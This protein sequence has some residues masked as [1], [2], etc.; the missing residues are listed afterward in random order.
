MI[1]LDLE[2]K[3]FLSIK[4]LKLDFPQGLILIDGFDEDRKRYC[5]TGKSAFLNTICYLYYGKFP[6]GGDYTLDEIVNDESDGRMSVSGTLEGRDHK[7]KIVRT[8]DANE[9]KSTFDIWI[10]GKKDAGA[11]DQRQSKITNTIGLTY[12]QFLLL[13]YISQKGEDRF[14]TM[15]SSDKKRFLSTILDLDRFDSAY[16]LAKRSADEKEATIASLTGSLEATRQMVSDCCGKVDVTAAEEAAANRAMENVDAEISSVTTKMA[17]DLAE[18]SVYEAG[19]SEGHALKVGVVTERIHG[20]RLS[21]AAKKKEVDEAANIVELQRNRLKDERGFVQNEIVRVRGTDGTDPVK[22]AA[23]SDEL[24]RLRPVI[25]AVGQARRD[26]TGKEHLFSYANKEI[27]R[28]RS[29][30]SIPAT[31]VCS[32]CG[33]KLP[34]PDIQKHLQSINIKIRAREEEAARLQE[35][36]VRYTEIVTRGAEIE[37]KERAILGQIEAERASWR[38][39]R[40]AA[41]GTLAAK[42]TELDLRI[43]SPDGLPALHKL[44]SEAGAIERDILSAQN[45]LREPQ[46]LAGVR[47]KTADLKRKIDLTTSEI[48]QRRTAA[49][50]AAKKAHHEATLNRDRWGNKLAESEASLVSVQSEQKYLLEAKKVF[51]PSGVRAFVFSDMLAH[52]NSRINHYLDIFWGGSIRFEY[53]VNEKGDFCGYGRHGGRK[54]NIALNSG[55]EARAISLA[56]DLALMDVVQTRAGTF[57]HILFLDEVTEGLDV[58]GKQALMRFLTELVKTRDRIYVIDHGTEFKAMFSQVIRMIKKSD[59]TRL[60]LGAQ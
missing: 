12:D 5:G 9:N 54:R 21:L 14:V 35:E 45:D 47:A 51:G 29:S 7:I 22:M 2:V 50:A 27:E 36:I 11:K 17:S 13:V 8:R 31:G 26:L 52:L 57:P 59:E 37:A 38:L 15:G 41:V 33:Q 18:L 34:E 25:A 6:A 44:E 48:M 10:D 60:E 58:P 4:S 43:K 30:L 40:D 20:L 56:V 49:L 19:L 1:P 55:G 39:K 53:S 46:E 32:E 3:N 23:L 16:V 24:E 42:L 28:L